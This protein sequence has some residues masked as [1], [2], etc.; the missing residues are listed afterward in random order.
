MGIENLK[1]IYFRLLHDINLCKQFL[2]KY[3]PETKTA[4][5]VESRKEEPR[6]VRKISHE[7]KKRVVDSNYKKYSLEEIR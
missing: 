6:P 2:E 1:F 7:T 5:K 4:I 3:Y